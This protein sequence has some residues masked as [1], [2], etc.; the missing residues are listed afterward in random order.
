M[1]TNKAFLRCGPWILKYAYFLKTSFH[2]SF[3]MARVHCSC[4]AQSRA[5][6]VSKLFNCSFRIAHALS[7]GGKIF[8]EICLKKWKK[9][10]FLAFVYFSIVFQVVRLF[11]I[12]AALQGVRLW[13][14]WYQ[15]V[16][17]VMC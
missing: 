13:K 10:I 3:S 7:K 8:E 2:E 6:L 15:R 9:V 12:C 14:K 11:S 1:Q 16:L 4:I 17:I 5:A